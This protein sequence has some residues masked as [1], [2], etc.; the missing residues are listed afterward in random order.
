LEALLHDVDEL[1]SY[2]GVMLAVE[3]T[4]LVESWLLV[5]LGLDLPVDVLSVFN[6]KRY[7]FSVAL[8]AHQH[9]SWVHDLTSDL[10]R[11]P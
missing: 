3:D 9:L 8:L 4:P 1:L 6:I 7:S 11:V 2:L 5:H 10:V